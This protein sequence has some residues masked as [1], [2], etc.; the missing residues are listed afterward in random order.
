[1]GDYPG[2]QGSLFKKKKAGKLDSHKVY[3]ATKEERETGGWYIAGLVDE[4]SHPESRN[5]GNISRS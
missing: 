5:V 3:E 1:M 2:S 4:G